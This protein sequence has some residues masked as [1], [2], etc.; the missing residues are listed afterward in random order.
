MAGT[1]T[2]PAVI[3][4]SGGLLLQPVAVA[5]KIA[6]TVQTKVVRIPLPLPTALLTTRSS[7][8][9]MIP[10]SGDHRIPDVQLLVV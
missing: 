3:L 4:A 8:L 10:D 1:T 7:L 2:F 6:N 9:R 5:S